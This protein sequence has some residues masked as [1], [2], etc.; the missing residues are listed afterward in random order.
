MDHHGSGQFEP[1]SSREEPLDWRHAREELT[2][3]A[4]TRAHLDWQEGRSLLCA[5]KTGAHLQLGYATF[6]EYIE[7]LFGYTAR[8][9]G[10]RLRVAEALERL[11]EIDQA[12]RDGVVSWSAVRELTRVA[13]P[14]NEHQWLAVA[15]GRSLRQIEELVSG[16]RLGDGPGER[17]APSSSNHVLRF[18][19]LAETFSTFREAM[20]K[21]RREFGGPM[22]DDAALLLM[23]RHA[24]GGPSDAGRGTYQI[25]LTVR[26]E[27]RRGWQQGNGEP[28]LV[29]AEIV[30][31]A[32][33]DAQH[34]GRIPPLAASAS[35]VGGDAH[36]G[37]RSPV[38]Q[39][40]SQPGHDAKGDTGNL[41]KA[42]APQ[43]RARQDVP[44]AVRRQVMR[45]DGG[46]CVVPGC[47]N[48]IFVDLHHIRLRSEGGDH[49]P[50]TLVVLC[51]AHHRAEHRGQLIIEGRV[52]TGLLVRHADGAR[53]GAIADPGVAEAHTQAFRALRALGFREGET[54][55]ALEQV[56]ADTHVGNANTEGVLRAALNVLSDT[57]RIRPVA[58]NGRRDSPATAPN[59][60]G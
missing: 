15:R 58:P 30:E 55:R 28:A 45:R 44:P 24:L 59:P 26:E 21:L 17:T 49:D 50:D 3:L 4:K 36:L 13:V 31:M 54:R 46:R 52:S 53:Y 60:G 35:H 18:E 32:C 29:G 47:S 40:P 51:A 57:R 11:F 20:A 41:P 19:V 5:L 22:D 39:A 10:E 56:R 14:E 42:A 12:L 8:W 34:L 16:H 23:A 25:A 38:Q 27:C 7:R 6:P 33:C 48:A 1:L 9:T 37:R 2:R 43:S